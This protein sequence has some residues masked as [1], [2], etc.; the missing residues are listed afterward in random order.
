M[1]PTSVGFFRNFMSIAIQVTALTAVAR[2]VLMTAIEASM[3]E[4]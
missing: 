4:P 1:A 2:S 3:L